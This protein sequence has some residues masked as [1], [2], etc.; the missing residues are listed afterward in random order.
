VKAAKPATGE[1]VLDVGC[2][3]GTLALMLGEKVGDDGRVEGVDA[4]PE[5]I[6]EAR[7]KAGS[8]GA[9]SRFQVAL[10]EQI[11]FEDD[12]FDLVVSSFM[13]HHLPK[14]L[15]RDG[16]TEIRRVLKPDGR[17][18][19]VDFAGDSD[20]L[21]GHLFSIFGGHS[22]GNDSAELL[23]MIE[24]AGFAEVRRLKSKRPEAAIMARGSTT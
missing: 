9:R 22:H 2:G 16:L 10:V 23:S 21:I 13:F 17:F 6:A 19:L 4:S 12:E 15:K 14:Q 3:T 18:L 24:D 20:S 7:K 5:M 1:A 11:P 8:G